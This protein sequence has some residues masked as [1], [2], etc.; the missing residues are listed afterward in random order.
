[1]GKCT[2]STV[3]FKFPNLYEIARLGRLQEIQQHRSQ[4]LTVPQPQQPADRSAAAA[5]RELPTARRWSGT[6]GRFFF[7]VEPPWK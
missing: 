4:S 5:G 3:M 6:E 1:M 2:I 7:G